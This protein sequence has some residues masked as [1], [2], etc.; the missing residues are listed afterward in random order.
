MDLVARWWRRAVVSTGVAGRT[1]SHTIHQPVSN[2]VTAGI[3]DR[4]LAV[5]Q[6]GHWVLFVRQVTVKVVEVGQFDATRVTHAFRPGVE[7]VGEVTASRSR[8]SRC[9][10]HSGRWHRS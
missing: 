7:P 2:A 3:A 1:W 10:P 9:R 4:G 5:H 8:R 6:S